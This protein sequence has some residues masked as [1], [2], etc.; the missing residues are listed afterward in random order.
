MAVP[1]F[2]TLMLPLLKLAGDGQQH[3]SAEAVESIQSS[4]SWRPSTRSHPSG[5]RSL[6][7]ARSIVIVYFARAWPAP[8]FWRC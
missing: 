6:M 7:S 5:T 2:Q 1:D 4:D 8:T 3:T